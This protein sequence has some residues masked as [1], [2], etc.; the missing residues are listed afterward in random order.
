MNFELE[1]NRKPRDSDDCR[2]GLG[3][4]FFSCGAIVWIPVALFVLLVLFQM[5]PL[6]AVVLKVVSPATYALYEEM[7]PED[8]GRLATKLRPASYARQA[9]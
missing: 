6:P 3:C 9:D 8:G 4:E 5:I 1:K 7:L 2:S